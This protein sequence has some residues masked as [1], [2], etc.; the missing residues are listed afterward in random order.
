VPAQLVPF[1]V[2]SV[3]LTVTPGPDMALVL[4]NGMA[5]VFLALAA[6]WWRMF[7]FGV[8][9]LGRVLSRQRVRT[10]I[11]RVAG[12]VLIGLGLRVAFLDH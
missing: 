4:R 5:A 1:L 3:V 8:A 12:T 2:V 11:E 9:A 7:S 6:V 10:A